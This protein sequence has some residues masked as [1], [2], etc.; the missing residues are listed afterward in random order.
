MVYIFEARQSLEMARTANSMAMSMKRLS[1]VTVFL[2]SF[3]SYT[4]LTLGEV[5][6][7]A[8]DVRFG[9]HSLCVPRYVLNVRL[10]A[11]GTF[12]DECRHTQQQSKLDLVHRLLR[13]INGFSSS[14]LASVQ[15][16]SRRRPPH[17]DRSNVLTTSQIARWIEENI[18]S[19]LETN[20]AVTETVQTVS[21]GANVPVGDLES[22]VQNRKSNSH[23]EGDTPAN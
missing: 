17:D 2:F 16:R 3:Q 4:V 23:P 13:T 12:R 6:F 1:W 11:I 21:S 19:R 9:N 18:G 8:V 15:I 5:Y 22:A 20:P 7:P 10:T 14:G